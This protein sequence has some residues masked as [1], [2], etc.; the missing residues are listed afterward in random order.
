MELLLVPGTLYLKNPFVKPKTYAHH[1]HG[2][3]GDSG[4]AYL[5]TCRRAHQEGHEYYYGRNMF[6]LP[7]GKILYTLEFFYE[8]DP[9]HAALIS[10]LG[11]NIGLS[12]LTLD[13]FDTT[14]KDYTNSEGRITWETPDLR[15]AVTAI[16]S[17]VQETWLDKLDHISGCQGYREVKVQFDN[18]TVLLDGQ[19]LAHE[20]KGIVS[21]CDDR[22][23]D[24]CNEQI[25]QILRAA[26]L[27][28][29]WQLELLLCGGGIDC[30]RRWIARGCVRPRLRKLP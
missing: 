22:G 9:K 1:T 14:M 18:S 21:W 30:V 12:H 11:V 27:A 26:K 6:Y 15:H 4:L 3:S 28:F 20:L 8:L 5:A 7:P 16:I 24:E 23:V 19:S 29:R 25:T 2:W 13:M 10:S 17:K